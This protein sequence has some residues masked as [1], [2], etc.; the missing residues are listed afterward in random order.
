[1]NSIRHLILQLVSSL[2]RFWQQEWVGQGSVF[3]LHDLPQG[4]REKKPLRRLKHSSVKNSK[5]QKHIC[6]G[7][8]G[9]EHVHLQ[10]LCPLLTLV[11]FQ[12]WMKCRATSRA[13]LPCTTEE[14]SCQGILGVVYLSM[15]SVGQESTFGCLQTKEANR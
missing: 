7:H 5:V 11:K 15:K 13:A 8:T 14:M 10:S 6:G 4:N 9:K 1:M 12:R 3:G 2:L